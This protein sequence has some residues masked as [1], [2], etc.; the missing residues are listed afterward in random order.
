MCVEFVGFR[1][2]S[3]WV[4]AIEHR[5]PLSGFQA[6]IPQS[7]RTDCRV[8]LRIIAG[9]ALHNRAI[10]DTRTLII[11]LDF[12]LKSDSEI[13]QHVPLRFNAFAYVVNGIG[14]FGINR[15][16]QRAQI[17]IFARDDEEVYIHQRS[18]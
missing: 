18:L 5:A 11:C 2:E 7:K 15:S 14:Y 13:V 12:K 16:V 6:P 1:V 17:V 9:E 4:R 10:I 8:S 3:L